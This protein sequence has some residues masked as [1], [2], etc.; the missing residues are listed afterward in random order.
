MAGRRSKD[1]DTGIRCATRV[2]ATAWPNLMIEGGYAESL[3]MLRLDDEWWLTASGGLTR[4]VILI[5]IK[6]NPNAIHYETWEVRPNMRRRTRISPPTVPTKIYAID[7][8]AAGVTSHNLPLIIPYG[9]LFDTPHPNQVD[10]QFSTNDLSVMAL[11][12][13]IH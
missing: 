7:I 12:V 4:I 5:H 9:T 8:D 2:G 1:G 6:K 13:Y 11:R 3:R 10:I